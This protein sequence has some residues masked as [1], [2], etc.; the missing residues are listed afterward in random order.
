MLI[1]NAARLH[2]YQ[3]VKVME[4][5]VVRKPFHHEPLNYS[6]GVMELETI[7]L[8]LEKAVPLHT[9]IAECNSSLSTQTVRHFSDN[10]A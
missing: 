9:L 10:C 4:L 7:L 1:E 5:L 3:A 6:N 2:T 8:E